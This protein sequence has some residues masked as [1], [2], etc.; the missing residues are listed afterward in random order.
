MC[1]LVKKSL[2][3]ASM[4]AAFLLAV[5]WLFV[6]MYHFLHFPT[7]QPGRETCDERVRCWLYK[8]SGKSGFQKR[9]EIKRRLENTKHEAENA[10]KVYSSWLS[11]P[12]EEIP[13]TGTSSISATS[14]Q[15][16]AGGPVAC[17]ASSAS[18]TDAVS[19][20]DD[21]QGTPSVCHRQ[22]QDLDL[23]D[24]A[25]WP[26]KMHDDARTE[27][28]RNKPLQVTDFDFPKTDGRRFTP[29]NYTRKIGALCVPRP[30]L[31]YSKCANSVFCFCCKL[32]GADKGVFRTGFSNWA[33]L[34]TRLA[35]HESYR[36]HLENFAKWKTLEFALASNATIDSNLQAEL[37]S[38]R[39][40]W[41]D[42]LTRILD[43]VMFLAKQNLPFRGSVDTLWQENNGN[44]LQLVQFLAKYDVALAQHLRNAKTTH[45]LSKNIQNEF[46][47]LLAEAVLE[48]I[49][50][51]VK[52]AGYY[53]IMMDC[54]PDV[55]HKEQLS[56]VLRYVT[57]DQKVEVHES[58]F[59][60]IDVQSTTGEDLANTLFNKLIEYGIDIEDCRGQ[61]FDNGANMRGV[62][63]GVQ[64]R[65]KEVNKRAFFVPC[66][67]HNLNL[68]IEHA[69]ESSNEAKNFFGILNR[70]YKLFGKST[71]RWA[72]LEEHLPITLKSLS[73]TR[74]SARAD[75]TRTV[76][77]QLPEVIDALFAVREDTTCDSETSSKVTSLVQAIESF[78]FL[79]S[80]VV[81]HKVLNTVNRASVILQSQHLSIGDAVTVVTAVKEDMEQYRWNGFQDAVEKAKE[82]AE[83]IDIPPTFPEHRTRRRKRLPGEMAMDD[84]LTGEEKFRVCFFNCLIDTVITEIDERFSYLRE[85]NR[86]FHILEDIRNVHKNSNHR[87]A[88]E[89][90]AEFVGGIDGAELDSEFGFLS[91]LLPGDAKTPSKVLEFLVDR[92]MKSAF[93]NTTAV[94]QVFLTIPFSVASAERSFSKLKL[95]KTYLRS[96]MS[97][98]RLSALAVLSIENQTARQVDYKDII[99]R[100][101]TAKTQ[102]IQF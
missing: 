17:S 86:L 71:K 9:K 62:H 51:K 84:P 46:I 90:L 33:K 67:P 27:I 44:F 29:A 94:C 64:A 97:Q 2:N 91:H 50:Q 31:V 74:W 53:S 99:T 12:T 15:D 75:A 30:W 79:V 54:T 63:R 37:E 92:D 48:K 61:C 65:V 100:F 98:E 102:R 49:V 3:A 28:V 101:A 57:T 55:S 70:L 6:K 5:F 87:E 93:P 34:S 73:E 85:C 25:Q 22:E 32:F 76:I 18:P 4:A 24:P 20:I 36:S 19:A 38:E 82:L 10:K 26:E 72:I 77:E 59:D 40:R 56:L 69:A 13:I 14:V 81:W 52:T 80:L 89:E 83:K 58:F 1:C 66:C 39:K 78:D 45:Y 16:G 11:R 47:G 68:A 23:F 7:H 96:T 95:I 41:Q 42:V 88:C 21:D 60:F 35:E 8:M 43:C